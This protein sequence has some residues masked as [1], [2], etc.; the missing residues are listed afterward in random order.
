MVQFG[1]IKIDDTSTL[2][3]INFEWALNVSEFQ[4]SL[5]KL[6]VVSPI[7]S[8]FQGDWQLE[9]NK[10]NENLRGHRCTSLYLR[11]VSMKPGIKKIEAHCKFTVTGKQFEHCDELYFDSLARKEVGKE[12]EFF[13]YLIVSDTTSGAL[14]GKMYISSSPSRGAPMISSQEG[15]WSHDFSLLWRK[16]KLTD[17]CLVVGG[18]K[19]KAHKVV[20]A[21]RS[22]VFLAM[23]EQKNSRESLIN[24]VEIENIEPAVV[25]AMLKFFYTDE[26]DN[27]KDVAYGLLGAADKYNVPL[28]KS[29]CEKV[30]Y[31]S[32]DEE[33]AAYMLIQADRHCS[34]GLKDYIMQFMDDH[35]VKVVKT[36]SYKHLEKYHPALVM[37][38]MRSFAIHKLKKVELMEKN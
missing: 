32:V 30:L 20:L 24:E 28:L 5:A 8:T 31:D 14:H 38:M 10:A 29:M 9:F 17:V 3:F 12:T 13:R 35:L 18:R 2:N 22:P 26:V 7:F 21:A 1:V 33:N 36:D 27:L 23:F 11:L 16:S 6:P 15:D 19:F 4:L 34:H 25:K 37:E